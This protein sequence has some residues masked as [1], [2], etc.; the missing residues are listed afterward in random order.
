MKKI[1]FLLIGIL[2]SQCLSAQVKGD[3]LFWDHALKVDFQYGAEKID[4]D[5]EGNILLLSSE[6]RQVFKVLKQFKY[7]S[8]I[9]I[10]GAS[11]REEALFHPIDIRSNNRQRIY[12]L[13]D[14]GQKLVLLNIN[15]KILQTFD[16]AQ[17][18]AASEGDDDIFPM[19]FCLGPTG[20]LFILNQWDNTILRFSNQL[21]PNGQ[22][23]GTNFGEGSLFQPTFMESSTQQQIFVWDEE[24]HKILVYSQYGVFLYGLELKDINECKRIRI[25]GSSLMLLDKSKLHL[26]HLPTKSKKS[27]LLDSKAE[28]HDFSAN[29]Q[30]FYFLTASGIYISPRSD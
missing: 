14:V 20:E 21:N 15:L 12:V 23:G 4:V 8:L 3:S 11:A 29:R 10:G 28:I 24:Q 22:F 7:D 25:V 9:S 26:V 27:F 19:G 1:T 30:N 18:N 6:D 17:V 2:A 16:F 5:V 13:D